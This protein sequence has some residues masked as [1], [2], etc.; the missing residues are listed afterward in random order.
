MRERKLSK[1]RPLQKIKVITG[2]PSLGTF[3][4]CVH[5]YGEGDIN[6]EEALASGKHGCGR[7]VAICNV[8][9]EQVPEGVLNLARSYRPFIKHVRV[10]ITAEQGSSLGY[11]KIEDETKK[12]MFPHDKHALNLTNEPPYRQRSLSSFSQDTAAQAQID[13]GRS[14]SRSL[15]RSLDD[16]FEYDDDKSEDQ[17]HGT[18][19]MVIML[20]ESMQVA[21]SFVENLHGKPFNI[22]EKDTVAAVYHV[23]KLEGEVSLSMN[24]F[25][26]LELQHQTL[27]PA[28]SRLRNR[29]SSVSSSSPPMKQQL[30]STVTNEENNCPV[31]LDPMISN[32]ENA[33]SLFTTVCNHTFHLN[34]LLQWEDAPCPVC[35]FDHAGINDTLSR[36]HVC[37]STEKIYVCL[38]C[39][40]ASCNNGNR[41]GTGASFDT[42]NSTKNIRAGNGPSKSDS[43]DSCDTFSAGHARD[44]YD[45]TLHAY[46]VD[47]ETQHVWDFAG[48]GYVHRLIQNED[49]GKIVEVADPQNTVNEERSL[50]PSL[51]DAEEGEVVHRKLEGYASEYHTLLKNQLS[52]QQIYFKRILQDI[53]EDHDAN[54]NKSKETA[55]SPS[56][57][58]SALKQDLNQLQQRQHTLEK[59]SNKVAE[60]VSFLKNMNES[61]EANKEPM[62]RELKEL[63][64]ARIEYSDML[65]NHLPPLEERI[66]VLMLKL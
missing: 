57:L 6:D 33:P 54:A 17:N 16:S 65:K 32:V 62:Q 24:S 37:G 46:A 56:A 50:V 3:E 4:G 28:R 8:P 44:H 55:R 12:P 53:R 48:Q 14:R 21:K 2:N 41:T 26:N 31:C 35:R 27:S 59:K 45:E 29:S 47:T 51:T 10:L 66:R 52:Q 15:A 18:H 1:S 13:E 34:C 49:D 58:I 7:M 39:G 42:N 30:K 36:C 20:L 60:N 9:P 43:C 11:E 64:K 38:I 40:V 19:Y 5:T 25:V 23:A 61:L 22:F 63:Q